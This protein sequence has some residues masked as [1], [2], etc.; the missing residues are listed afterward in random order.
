MGVVKPGSTSI[1]TMIISIPCGVNLACLLDARVK[2]SM[3]IHVLG[4][5]F[6]L[7]K[8]QYVLAGSQC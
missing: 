4:L 7:Q 3:S 2:S 5:R 8:L 1:M 6:P